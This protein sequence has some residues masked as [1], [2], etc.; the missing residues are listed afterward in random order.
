MAEPVQSYWDVLD[1]VWDAMSIDSPEEFLAS[2]A[3]VPRPVVLL[4]AAHFC[5]SELCNGGLLQFFF[6]STGVLAPEAAEGF[7]KIGLVEVSAIVSAASALLGAQYPRDRNERWDA[8]LVASGLSE[9]QL[10][11]IFD[12]SKNLYLSFYEAT[13]PLLL[14]GFDRQFFKLAKEEAGGFSKAAT[15]YAR[16]LGRGE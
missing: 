16:G 13:K 12:E 5:Y 9:T 6:N 10:K 2:A 11:T 7:Q 3:K 8:L 15:E 1:P 4:Y 14:D